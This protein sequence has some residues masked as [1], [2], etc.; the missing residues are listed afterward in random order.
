MMRSNAWS[1]LLAPFAAAIPIAILA[2][3]ARE[4]YFARKWSARADRFSAFLHTGGWTSEDPAPGID[5]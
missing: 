3:L 2:N 1:Y 5:F 4:W